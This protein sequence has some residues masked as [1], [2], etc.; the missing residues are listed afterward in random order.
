MNTKVMTNEELAAILRAM[1]ATGIS[2]SGF[3]NECLTE[4]AERLERSENERNIIN[5]EH[6]R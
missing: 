3:E 2:V 6:D 1:R 5:R 4:A